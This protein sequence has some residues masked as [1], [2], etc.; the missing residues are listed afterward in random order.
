MKDGTQMALLKHSYDLAQPIHQIV[1]AK[2][3]ASVSQVFFRT[4]NVRLVITHD[5]GG[6]SFP[7]GSVEELQQMGDVELNEHIWIMKAFPHN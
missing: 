3:P 4:D 1:Q 7:L 6:A 5:G 2:H